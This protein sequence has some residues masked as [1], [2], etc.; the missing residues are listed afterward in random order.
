MIA[1]DILLA[2]STGVHLHLC[3][4]STKGS[5]DFIRLA[6]QR[7]ISVSA[8]VCPHHFALTEEAVD[9][10]DANTKMSPPLRSRKM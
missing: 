10:Y 6:K 1:R 3:H 8:E 7:G 9:G 2:E 5:L 4:V